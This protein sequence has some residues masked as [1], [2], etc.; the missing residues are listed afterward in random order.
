M[1]SLWVAVRATLLYMAVV[2]LGMLY[3]YRVADAPYG[4]VAMVSRFWPVELILTCL[5][6]YY[7]RRYYGCSGAGFGTMRWRGAFWL[8]PSYVVLAMM[9]AGV[10]PLL[11]HGT[12]SD[13]D[14]H[15]LRL[16]TVTTF[17]IGFS[18]EVMFRG[19]LLRGLI[20]RLPVT[21]AMLISAV[22]FSLLHAVNGFD[23]QS[24]TNIAQ[25][26]AF[27]FLVGTFLAPAA[28]KIGNLWPLIVWH[29]LWD[30]AVFSSDML[31]VLHP[32]ALIGI[33]IQAVV[34]LWLWAD[35]LRQS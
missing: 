23:G 15:M 13:A 31:G 1:P 17:L 32:F 27:T 14:W 18:E 4:T 33:L 30:L 8:L 3:M 28:L 11:L 21:H 5:C 12:L 7:V 16:L 6:V 24:V 35:L 10:V 2:G 9:G 22:A 34:G 25:Q 19:I 29:W 20:A 26:L